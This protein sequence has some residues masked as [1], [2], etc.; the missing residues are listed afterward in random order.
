MFS[1][2]IIT[3][4]EVFE[5]T[6]I[7]GVILRCLARNEQTK[8]NNVIYGGTLA[9]LALSILGALGFDKFA[10]GFAGRAEEIFQGTA[11][12]VGALLLASM[13]YWMKKEN[14][15]AER[16][17]KEAEKKLQKE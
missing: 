9:G 6:L 2:F 17:N 16:L 1:S 12:L 11:L 14:G 13:I 3:F 10:G 4:R 15:G 8:F 5:I 7:V